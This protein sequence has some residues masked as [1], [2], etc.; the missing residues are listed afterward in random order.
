MKKIRKTIEINAS[1]EKVWQVLTEDRY[2]RI[3]YAEFHPESHAVT[4]WKVGSTAYFQDNSGN[5]IVAKIIKNDPTEIL[6]MEY[7]GMLVNGK[8]DYESDM[9][10]DFAG[11][12]ETY[13][14]NEK[15]G[16]TTLE[17]EGDMNEEMYDMM[18]G[19]W[20]K[21]FAKFKELAEQN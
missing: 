18:S 11:G 16:V 20:E 15:E 14:M 7:T 21:A 17:L 1:K 13:I 9:A 5:G 19:L 12:R 10:K 3:W 2:T 8:E 6:S 4:D